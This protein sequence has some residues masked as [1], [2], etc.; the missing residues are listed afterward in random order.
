MGTNKIQAKYDNEKTTDVEKKANELGLSKNKLVEMYETMVEIRHFEEMATQLYG[1]GKVHGTMHLSIGQEAVAVG[2]G[3][4]LQ[5][6]DYLMNHH[7]G[8]GHF[9]AS[10]ADVNKMM[11]EFLGKDTGFCHGRGGSMHIADVNANNLGAQGI[12]GAQMGIAVGVGIAI[13]INKTDQVALV[14]FG[15]GA[16]NRGIFHESLNMASIWNLPI[17]YLCENNHYGMSAEVERVSGKVPFRDR[18]EALGVPGYFVDGNDALAV[19]EYLKKAFDHARQGLG[20]VFLEVETYRHLGHSKSDRNLYR[21]KE[22]IEEW[23]QKCPIRS[24]RNLLLEKNILTENQIDEIDKKMAKVIED[25]VEYAENSPEP[26]IEDVT[27]YVYA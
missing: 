14:I 19:Y 3:L 15:D 23:K 8:H 16:A 27:E 2:T 18:A 10:G 22:E 6:N 17:V 26:K 11:A 5:S 13:K 21:S 7:R 25:A 4:T 9:I 1:L 24:F 12:V 20:P